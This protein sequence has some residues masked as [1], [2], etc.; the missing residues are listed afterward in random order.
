VDGGIGETVKAVRSRLRSA[1]SLRDGLHEPYGSAG[2]AAVGCEAGTGGT[3][4]Q[5]KT[6]REPA[7]RA[8]VTPQS[9]PPGEG[10][11][12]HLAAKP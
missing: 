9:H 10:P 7:I 4:A 12:P 1:G 2:Q 5:R 3:S 6:S 8:S 11:G